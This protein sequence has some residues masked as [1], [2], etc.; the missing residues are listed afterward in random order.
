MDM[1]LKDRFLELWKKYFGGAGLPLAF[2]YSEDAE[3]T[4][5]INLPKGHRCLLEDLAPVRQGR[6]LRFDE[7]TVGCPG[8]KRY[9]GFSDVVMPNFEYF[10]SCGIP[11]KLE[12][13]RYKKTPALVKEFDRQQQSFEAPEQYIVFKRWDMIGWGDQPAAVVFFAPPD[14]L[15]GLFT[16]AN[17][18]EAELDG[19]YCPFCAGC[20]SIVKYPFLENAEDRPRAVLGMF[21]VSARPFVPKTE[22]TF[23]V[24]MKKFVPMVEDMEESFL[25]TNSWKAIQR[26]IG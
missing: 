7:Y 8:G 1:K 20:G 4:E 23:S 24:P 2:W 6:S 18:A 19:V 17:F 16:L 22:L 11:G 25:T 26:R 15:S 21:D 10:L 14:V 3:G 13:E 12:G 9:L 5:K